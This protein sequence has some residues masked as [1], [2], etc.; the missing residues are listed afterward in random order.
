MSEQATQNVPTRVTNERIFGYLQRGEVEKVAQAGSEW[1]RTQIREEGFAFKFLPLEKATDDMLDRDLDESLRIIV[2][3]EPDSPGAKWVPLQTVPEGE[4]ITGSRYQVPF[5]RVLT[6]KYQKDIDELRTYKQDIRKLLNDIA[7]KEGLAEI[8]GKF[9]A[10]CNAITDDVDGNGIHNLTGKMQF[11]ALSGGITKNNW[12]DAKKLL[13]RGSQTMPGKFRLRNYI[14]L[15]NDVT[16]QD[17][18]K[19]GVEDIGDANVSRHYNEGLFQDAQYGVKTVF[20]LKDD[21][22][23]DN[24]VYFFAAPEFLGKAYYM[25]DW[26]MFMK[27]E[28]FFIEW[29]N[30]WMGGFAFGNV[31]GVC[32]VDF[33]AVVGS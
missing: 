23:P 28:A 2:E 31:A 24:V 30:Y 21:L 12:I 3:L 16:A 7:I 25:T 15:M 1:T 22:V 5:A 18:Q 19:L 9:V 13:P 29:F 17:W 4:Y 11:L 10:T 6:R 14:A 20:T 33:D 26:T 27:K 32:K 8:D